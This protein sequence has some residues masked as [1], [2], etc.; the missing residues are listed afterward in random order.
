MDTFI[1][2]YNNAAL[3][4]DKSKTCLKPLLNAQGKDTGFLKAVTTE[5]SFEEIR[6]LLEVKDIKN[7]TDFMPMAD[8]Y[9]LCDAFVYTSVLSPEKQ[10]GEYIHALSWLQGNISKE[11]KYLLDFTHADKW[12]E[13]LGYL[14]GTMTQI[15]KDDIC[16]THKQQLDRAYAINTLKKNYAVEYSFDS[17]YYLIL[18]K[19]KEVAADVAKHMAIFGG[20][21][22][23]AC[24]LPNFDYDKSIDRLHIPRQGTMG[25]PQMQ[26]PEIPL[27]YLLNLAIA[28]LQIE[29]ANVNNPEQAVKEYNQVISLAATYCLAYYEA[30]TYSIWDL[31]FHRD[32]SII[33]NW[34]RLTLKDGLNYFRQTSQNYIIEYCDYISER[35][36]KDDFL[37]PLPFSISELQSIYH[38]L[39]QWTNPHKLVLFDIRRVSSMNHYEEV[40]EAIS[41]PIADVNTGFEIANDYNKVT[42]WESSI[43]KIDAKRYLLLP[44]SIGASCWY[45]KLTSILRDNCKKGFDFQSWLGIVQEDYVKE[46]FDS[47][48][49]DVKFGKYKTQWKPSEK[50]EE[51]EVDSIIEGTDIKLIIESK[52]KSFTRKS[53]SGYDISIL[54]DIVQGL[55][56]SQTQAFRTAATLHLKKCIELCDEQWQP[57]SNVYY[58]D[59]MIEKITLTYGDYGFFQDRILIDRILEDVTNHDFAIELNS[60]PN[61]ILSSAEKIKIE[62]NLKKMADA[63]AMMR[64]YITVM[65]NINEELTKHVFFNCWHLNLE[66]LVYLI[67]RSTNAESFYNELKRCKH[68]CYS[69]LDFWNERH[70]ADLYQIK[71]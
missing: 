57:L 16:D 64:S 28:N 59:E 41:K 17:H 45:D 32:C 71:S 37:K 6:K 39:S 53:L 67:S 29:N 23:L 61:N 9:R 11:I 52:T 62:K 68:V 26:K 69:T 65:S 42:Y 1:R 13:A 60:V 43:I 48:G 46:K 51:G 66:Q 54:F 31:I 2:L 70:I 35:A 33:E 14:K 63:Q 50:A 44:R 12:L 15:T 7:R 49:I 27:N 56:I 30:Q 47:I 22:F 40:L 4:K 20:A 8:I 5:S 34:M 36:E 25:F 21:R 19:E 38:K 55:F 10:V 58:S 3:Q 18:S 24:F